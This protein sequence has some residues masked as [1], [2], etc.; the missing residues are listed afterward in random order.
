MSYVFIVLLIVACS[1]GQKPTAPAGKAGDFSDLFGLFGGFEN[2]EEEE[3][4]TAEE[5]AEM[6]STS[7]EGGP[8]LIVQSPSVSDSMLTPEQAFTLHANVHNQGDE[9]AAATMLHYYRSNNATI[10]SLDTEVGT[11]AIGTLAAS[12]SSVVS[13][14]LTAPTGGG[15]GVYFYGACVDSV[16]GES[17]TDNNCS[18]AVRITVSG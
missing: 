12:D 2:S 8:D 6:D 16:N 17:N 15:P 13:I 4:E 3:D 10:T 14:A 7:S 18:S 11:D 9:Q 1:G 5:E